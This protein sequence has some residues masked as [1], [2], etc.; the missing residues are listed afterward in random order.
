M[1]LDGPAAVHGEEADPPTA[2]SDGE[3]FG[4]GRPTG[5]T[6]AIA[7]D[8]VPRPGLHGWRLPPARDRVTVIEVGPDRSS[9]T[10]ERVSR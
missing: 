10:E 5:V 8:S 9:T 2:N 1:V 7:S 3:V 4:V 6:G